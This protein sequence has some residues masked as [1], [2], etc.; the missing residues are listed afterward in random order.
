MTIFAIITGNTVSEIFDAGDLIPG[1]DIL[2]PETVAV[3]LTGAD[4]VPA[5]GWSAVESSGRWLFSAPPVITPSPEQLKS[6]AM[7][8]RAILLSRANEHTVGMADAFITG[9]LD[10]ADEAMY[11]VWAAYKLALNKIDKQGGYPETITWPA[12]PSL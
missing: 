10:E 3:D 1:V 12:E 7:A 9:L 8:Q 2:T 11:K 5:A 4:P 6:A